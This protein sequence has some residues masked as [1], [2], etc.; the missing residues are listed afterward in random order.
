MSISPARTAAFDILLRVEQQD[1]Y[2]SELLH[3]GPYAK[4]SPADH[5]LATELV[6]G[7]LRW[8]SL[9]DARIGRFSDKRLEKLN[10]EVLTALRL[11]A[12]QL[13]FLDRVPG[14]AA[15]HQSVELV[16]RARK[17]SAAPFANAVLR[18]LAASAPVVERASGD[19]IANA[20]PRPFSGQADPGKQ[21]DASEVESA[22]ELSLRFAHPLWLVERWARQFGLERVWQTCLYDQLGSTTKIR[23]SDA[24]MEAELRRDGIELAPGQL[25]ASARWV[26]SGSVSRTRAFAEGRVAIQDEASQLVALLV[27]RGSRILDCCA[28][29]GGKTRI[30]AERNPNAGI[31]ALE[32]HAHRARLLRKL[33]PARNVEVI[34]ADVLDFNASSSFDRVLADV[35]CSGT[36]T[37]AHNP[38]IKWRLK[39][40]DLA[41]LQTR[42]LAIL[43]AGMRLVAAGGRLVYSTCSLE[44]EENEEV[45]EKALSGQTEFSVF[46]CRLE[47]EHLRAE[48]ELAWKDLDSLASGRFL[49]TVPGVHPCDGFFVAMLQKS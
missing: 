3:S 1:A 34:N 48:G 46:D 8:Q 10:I 11:A 5:G 42:Q 31:V 21:A 45:V 25:L 40:G 14:R 6:M 16:R 24:G 15:V 26:R 41:D 23:L 49:R 29:P 27:G 4:L 33:V 38:E 44:P 36:G 13:S 39:P 19:D 28:A 17:A 47:L 2:A 43:R 18:K 37:L 32:L 12:Y 30:V 9:L 35:P 20:V 7:V 22:A